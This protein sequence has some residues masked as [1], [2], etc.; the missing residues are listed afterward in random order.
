MAV[1]TLLDLGLANAEYVEQLY[2][3]FHKDPKSVDGQWAEFFAAVEAQSPDAPER[4]AENVLVQK[5]LGIEVANLVHAYRE[6]GH[7]SAPL[8]PLGNSRPEHPLL[9]LTEYGLDDSYL[10]QQ[11]GTGGF[12][13]QTGG[14]L[15]ELLKRLR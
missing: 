10:D 5:A 9:A 6:L 4:L 7:F 1:N 8:D 12:L 11:V 2:Q 13:G 15:R 14:T 3:E